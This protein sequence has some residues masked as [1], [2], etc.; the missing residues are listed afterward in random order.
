M[1]LYDASKAMQSL[2]KQPKNLIKIENLEFTEASGRYRFPT[3][4][5]HGSFWWIEGHE[6]PL[7]NSKTIG[8]YNKRSTNSC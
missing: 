4:P 5:P 6:G 7:S 2:N 1:L 3:G 8:F